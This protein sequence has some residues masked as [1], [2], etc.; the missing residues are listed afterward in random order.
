MRH[1]PTAGRFRAVLRRV[2]EREIGSVLALFS[3]AIG[4]L[5][6]GKIAS[7]V[8]EGDS[9]SLDRMVLLA[10]RSPGDLSVPIGPRWLAEAARDITAL[11]GW[12]VLALLTLASVGYLLLQRKL[13]HALFLAVAVIGAALLSLL[14]K[15]V[16]ARPRPELVPHLVVVS[17]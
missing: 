17:S 1:E 14:L 4:T 11:G 12:V 9:Q 16:F 13:R 7:E 3:V 8:S 6:F 2:G 10:L 15:D 5:A